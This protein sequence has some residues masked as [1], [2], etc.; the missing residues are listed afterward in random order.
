[1]TLLLQNGNFLPIFWG[2]SRFH[3]FLTK[4]KTKKK[5]DFAAARLATISATR[6]TENKLFFKGG[7]SFHSVCPSFYKIDFQI[8]MFRIIYALATAN[9]P[10][11][12]KMN[13][14][15]RY[16]EIAPINAKVT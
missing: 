2:G 6:Y 11:H 15:V 12:V 10:M 3:H 14:S 8:E 7:L 5:K 1:M 13:S 9:D 4:K 16:N